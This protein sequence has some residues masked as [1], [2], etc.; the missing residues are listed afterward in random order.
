[1]NRVEQVKAIV[2]ALQL[3]EDAMQHLYGTARYC[4]ILAEKRG[5]NTE[6]AQ[7]AG[8]L[9]DIVL[10]LSGSHINHARRSAQWAENLLRDLDCFTEE[11]IKKIRAA[12][13]LH[14]DKEIVHDSFAELL[15]EADIMEKRQKI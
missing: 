13:Y 5:E 11:E 12:I 1:M 7:I 3:P 10:F 6:L 15:K 8:M 2:D 14:S 9:H 4:A